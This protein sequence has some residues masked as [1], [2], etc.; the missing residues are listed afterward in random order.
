MVAPRQAFYIFW[1]CPILLPFWQEVYNKVLPSENVSSNDKYLFQILSAASRKAI[2]RK[3]LKLEKP[4]LTS[5]ITFLKMERILFLK[6]C[7]K[8]MRYVTPV[9]P[10]FV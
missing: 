10:S 6:R 4:G 1:S 7:E 9:C 8:W 2:T 3:W 5:F